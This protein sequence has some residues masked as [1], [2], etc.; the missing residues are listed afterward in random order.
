MFKVQHKGP[1]GHC[2]IDSST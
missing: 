1:R 2:L